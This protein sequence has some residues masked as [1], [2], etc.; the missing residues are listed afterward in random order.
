MV[1]GAAERAASGEQSPGPGSTTVKLSVNVAAEV[2]DRL[3]HVAFEH[4]L[5]ES[6]IVEVALRLLFRDSAGTGLGAL[7]RQQGASLRRRRRRGS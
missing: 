5:S 6:S 3:R 1:E 7:L 4:R 2:G